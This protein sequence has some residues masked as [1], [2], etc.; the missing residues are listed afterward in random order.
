MSDWNAPPSTNDEDKPEPVPVPENYMPPTNDGSGFIHAQSLY[1]QN[2]V[3][4]ELSFHIGT[5]S[6]EQRRVL[7]YR[8][9]ELN[10]IHRVEGSELVASADAATTVQGQLDAILSAAVAEPVAVTAEPTAPTDWLQP[11]PVEA[12]PVI[13]E[14]VVPRTEPEEITV[15]ESEDV[16]EVIEAADADDDEIVF[17]L[18][19]LSTE[20]RRHLSMRLT[21]AGIAH[22][23]EVATDLIVSV[24]DAPLIETY[25]EEVRNP[26]GFADHELDAF[27]SDEDVDDEQVYAAMSNLYVASDRL[28]QRPTDPSIRTAFY[29]ATDGV[30]GLPAPFG[31]DPRVWTQVCNLANTIA[32][33][34]DAEVDD[35]AVATDARTLRQLLVNYV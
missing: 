12:E 6:G 33:A 3:L 24:T 7:S 30:D 22:I 9:R 5:L 32:D 23:W 28:M 19:S 20:E 4:G 11:A 18:A 13:D 25:L 21:G 15:P 26:D 29:D 14:P 34:M 10:V 2:R 35:E 27:E 17:D 31:F 8:L 1:K 16:E